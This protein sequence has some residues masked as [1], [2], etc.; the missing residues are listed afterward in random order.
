MTEKTELS[1]H[2]RSWP[3]FGKGVK[4]NTC[5]PRSIKRLQRAL[6]GIERHLENHYGDAA[7]ST[8]AANLKRRI[9]GG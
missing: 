6:E 8:R 4:H 7:A 2:P 1:I 5:K 9:S 3:G